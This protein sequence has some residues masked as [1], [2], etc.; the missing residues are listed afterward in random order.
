MGVN[1]VNNGKPYFFR[2]DIAKEGGMDARITDYLKTRVNDNGKKVPVKWFDQ[3]MV[4]NVHGM[5]P[6]IQGGVGHWT[7]DDNNELLPGSDVVYRD[8]Q[9]TPADVTDDGMVYYTLEDQF[10]CKQGQ[11]KGIF[12]LRD[13]NG[14]VFSSVNI[15][16]EIQGNDFRIHQT[17]EYYSSELEKMKSKF[18]NDTD[19]VI[20]DAKAS[21]MAE[22]QNTREALA[23]AQGS[24]QTTIDAQKSLSTQVAGM[25]EQI[26]TQ[27]I[28]TK[29]DFTDLSNQVTQQ[30]T[31][32]KESGLEFF[33]NADD[34]RSTYP[35]GA[36]KLCVTLN[37]SHQWVYDY[38]NHAW[39]D[40]GVYSYGEI[41]PKLLKAL[42]VSNPDNIIPN[43]TFDSVDLWNIGRNVTNPSYYVERTNRGNALVL[44]GYVADNSS[45]E[46]WVTTLPF[47]TTDVSQISF[48]AE[49]AFS[50]IDYSNGS[51]VSIEFAWDM[52]DGSTS[53]YHRD[54]PSYYQ[55]GKYHKI[56]A[57]HIDFPAG[58]PQ[59][60]HI[61]FVFYGNGQLKIR[62]PQAN[63]GFKLNPYSAGDLAEKIE[64]S[65]KN[66]LLGQNMADWDQTML[67]PAQVIGNKDGSI[68]IDGTANPAGQYRWISSDLINVSSE[69]GLDLKL[70]AS[71]NA[72]EDYGTYVEI[73]QY[74]QN[75]VALSTIDKYLPNSYEWKTY[76][77]K[78]INLDPATVYV[79]IR[80]VIKGQSK[81]LISQIEASQSENTDKYVEFPDNNWSAFEASP[82]FVVSKD[83]TIT[84]HG[85]STTKIRSAIDGFHGLVSDYIPVSSGESLSLKV[86]ACA[87]VDRTTSDAFIEVSQYDDK[88]QS[89]ATNNIDIRVPTSGTLQELVANEIK[90]EDTTRYITLKAVVKNVASLNIA[91][92]NYQFNKAYEG[93][94]ENLFDTAQIAQGYTYTPKDV[95]IN[96]NTLMISTR[97][98]NGSYTALYSPMIRVKPGSTIESAIAAKVGL[99]P[100]NQGSAYYELQQFNKYHDAVNN[101]T[102]LDSYFTDTKN[103]FNK[104][105]FTNRVSN[106][107]NW[108]RYALVV[109]GN[110]D[111]QVNDISARY[112]Q[113]MDMT[114]E[115]KLPQLYIQNKSDIPDKWTDPVP[116]KF[117]DGSR[118]VTG[119]VQY[120]MQGDSSKG[121]PKK[122]LKVKFFLDA[123]GKEKLKWKPKASWTK[124]H[125][126]NI[127]ANYIDAT[128]ARNLVNGQIVKNAYA[129]TQI[130][131][132]TVAKKLLK[133]QSLGQM[134]GFPTELYFD[135][136]YYGLM[137]FNTK[138][139]D[140]TF[141]MNS[142]KATD[143]VITSETPSSNLDN[144]AAK[145]DGSVYGTEI[146]DSASEELNANWTKFLTFINTSS[147]TDFKAKLSDYLDVNSIINVLLF[148]A[149][150][151]EWDFYNKS[152]L[153]LT[154]DSG[155]S[156][157]AIPYDLDSTWNLMWNGSAI[158]DNL[159]DLSWIN[160]SNNQNKL[161]HRLYDNFK[162]EIKAQWE[163]LRS[164][165]WQ[166]DKALNM[167][168]NYI[169]SIPES[170]YEKDQQK[171]PDIPSA[172]ITDYGQ[173]QQSII[174]RG[175]AMDKFMGGL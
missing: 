60:M 18:K 73:Y 7:P 174:E 16:F 100:D 32:M 69:L 77:F 70:I 146:H 34:L 160:G 72:T 23:L 142:D 33:N 151:H 94:T 108:V 31:Q 111:L 68:T 91:S 149:W 41:D 132:S 88:L 124:N 131:D 137:T 98:K 152:I 13:A 59:T 85:K 19:Q 81:L 162:P 104:F 61:G 145:I 4:M 48:G 47:A 138:K 134:E 157:F 168:K 141:G 40:A 84:S 89:Q 39:N 166:T 83:T 46:S 49:I 147:D 28:V 154:W 52:P 110:A 11:F 121:Y 150:S 158:D 3:G 71:A 113:E 55:D 22:T 17:T 106:S 163:K 156:Y 20:N 24:I 135:D 54:I 51:N 21:Y 171:W 139:D 102:N 80:L 86:L 164:G 144:V 90:L 159:T 25:E 130:A 118:K 172:K 127:K 105:E 27:N 107:T 9:G 66:L 44:N 75:Q 56:S 155:K 170:A 76:S 78:N 92:L 133:T 8:W 5:S 35:D 96:G 42:Y 74:D 10:F 64:Q 112:A 62:R 136:G 14:N 93:N 12:G 120:A 148:G 95:T 169:D 167:F 161:L 6:F 119:F 1:I 125:K 87:N 63:F 67:V 116:F 26:N 97:N 53:Y 79:Q 43:S 175:E 143:E 129:I 15:I 38:A 126:F 101:S 165:V 122:N 36:N 30:I 82:K 153:F 140:K 45:N 103:Q 57:L 114:S 65:S 50:G 29:K 128:Q 58:N 2:F 37:N 117:I 109:Y 173:I 115:K 99:L 123:K